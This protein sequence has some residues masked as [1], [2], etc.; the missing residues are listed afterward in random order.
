MNTAVRRFVAEE[1][2]NP[3]HDCYDRDEEKCQQV[4]KEK[5]VVNVVDERL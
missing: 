1:L 2:K 3:S 4:F 5:L